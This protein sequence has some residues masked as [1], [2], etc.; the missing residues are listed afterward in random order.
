MST[1]SVNSKML[2]LGAQIPAIR[3]AR[4]SYRIAFLQR[5]IVVAKEEQRVAYETLDPDVF[6]EVNAKLV[7][8]LVS[9]NLELIDLL[10]PE[11][12]E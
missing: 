3:Q 5:A 12:T 4:V 1:K 7:A 8:K 10:H 11:V 9:L 6:D 2:S